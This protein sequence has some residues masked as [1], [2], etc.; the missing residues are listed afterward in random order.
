M[1]AKTPAGGR[2]IVPRGEYPGLVVEDHIFGGF[3]VIG[4]DGRALERVY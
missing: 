4:I 1:T 3:N 2:S